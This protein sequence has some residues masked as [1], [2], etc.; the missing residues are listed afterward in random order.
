MDL[1]TVVGFVVAFGSLMVAVFM[2]G[3]QLGPLMSLPPAIIVFGGTLGA[4]LVSMPLREV[5]RM[6]GLLK[7]AFFPQLVSPR[8][9]AQELVR[10]AGIARRKGLLQL[11][12]EVQNLD[13]P[14]LAKGLALVIDGTDAELIRETMETEIYAMQARHKSGS[15]MFTTMGGLAPTLG[16]TGTVM[17]LVN[18]LANVDDPAAMG[19]AISVAFLATLYGV[20]AANLFYLPVAAKLTVRSEEEA[21]QCELLLEGLMSLQA[22]LSPMMVEER[23]KSFLRPQDRQWGRDNKPDSRAA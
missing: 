14:F 7:L 9:M 17:G 3:G 2:E 20:G 22:G 11:E 15:K 1:G 21:N 23:L 5:V 19:P 8:D 12:S 10:L 18:M 6:P 13:D 16:V 4:T